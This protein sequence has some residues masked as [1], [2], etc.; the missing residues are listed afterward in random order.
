MSKMCDPY[1]IIN[2]CK[3]PYPKSSIINP[4]IYNLLDTLIIQS[5]VTQEKMILREGRAIYVTSG[6]PRRGTPTRSVL[7][8]ETNTSFLMSCDVVLRFLF[9]CGAKNF[10]RFM[11]TQR[12]REFSNRG[13]RTEVSFLEF[14]PSSNPFPQFLTNHC[15]PY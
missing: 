12:T 9:V 3:S 6:I 11:K 4:C 1:V 10:S 2:R 5:T 7:N 15:F 14:Y 8:F 13:K